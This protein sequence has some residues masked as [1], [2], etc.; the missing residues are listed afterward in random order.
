MAGEAQ[1]FL[2]TI[3]AL[4][5]QMMQGA[6]LTDCILGTVVNETPLEIKVDSFADVLEE[7]DLILTNA[8]KDHFVDIEVAWKT[9]EDNYLQG[10]QQIHNNNVSAYNSHTHPD[11]GGASSAMKTGNTTHLHD[12][13]GRKKIRVYNGLKV[14]ET[15][16]LL[17]KSGG[18]QYIVWDRISEHVTNGEWVQS[19]G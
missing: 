4:I 1:T 18:Q 16:L 14:G 19:E 17:R 12:I 13:K 8:V 6:N 2:N 9:V 10:F 11:T 3:K 5:Q 15:V 7:N